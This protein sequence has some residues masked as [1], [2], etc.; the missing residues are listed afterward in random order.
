MLSVEKKKIKIRNSLVLTEM[1][2]GDFLLFFSNVC[3]IYCTLIYMYTYL[4]T[5]YNMVYV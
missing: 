3:M 4:Y 2:K 5:I 1:K